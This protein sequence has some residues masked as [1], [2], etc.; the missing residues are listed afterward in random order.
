MANSG[1]CGIF[2]NHKSY[3]STASRACTQYNISSYVHVKCYKYFY[4]RKDLKIRNVRCLILWLCKF[5]VP[6]ML[7]C[8]SFVYIPS[9]TSNKNPWKRKVVNPVMNIQINEPA[10][11][12][13]FGLSIRRRFAH[14]FLPVTWSSQH[15]VYWQDMRS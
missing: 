2:F 14:I 10:D 5:V 7:I 12:W 11:Q 8:I 4:P 13:T 1:S 9:L 6:L 15:N 3:S